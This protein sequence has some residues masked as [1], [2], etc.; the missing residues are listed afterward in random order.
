MKKSILV[1]M[2]I[3]VLC[4]GLIGVLTADVP[5]PQLKAKSQKWEYQVLPF[6]NEQETQ[7]QLNKA[8][9][10]GWELISVQPSEANGSTVGYGFFF[11]KRPLAQ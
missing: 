4:L 9:K 11:L 2:T 7:N 3:A 10:D 5:S 1:G 6:S 8:G